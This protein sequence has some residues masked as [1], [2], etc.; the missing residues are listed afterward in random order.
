M[1]R[2]TKFRFAKF[3]FASAIAMA[4]TAA[5]FTPPALAQEDTD[6]RLGTVHFATSCNETAQ[7]R[8]DRGMRYQHSFWYR[9]SEGDFR[10]CAEGRPVLRHRVLGHCAEPPLEPAQRADTGEPAG[11][12][13]G[14]AERQGAWSEDRARAR[15]Y[16]LAP[17]ALHR[18]RQGAARPACTG[19]SQGSR[20]LGPALS[21]RRRGAAQLR[22]HA[23]RRGLAQRQDL[24]QPAQGR[25]DPGA[26]L[27][28]S[29]A[30][31]RRCALPDPSLRHACAGGA[32]ARRR[33]AL[34]ADR[35]VGA[36]RAAHAV[37]HLHARGLLEGLDFLEHGVGQGRAGE[38]G[39]VRP[40]ARPGL[41]GLRLSAARAGQERPCG[42][43]TRC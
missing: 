2:L 19:L 9:A 29:A 20:G 17:G 38:Q 4:A 7:R 27:Q 3:R 1:F 36:A 15:V 33:Q 37:A 28:A 40:A 23:Q 11:G 42:D 14:P 39:G 43:R 30:S 13:R 5:S 16:R 6:Q 18:L 32:R 35:A 8:F 25:C 21:G 26:D 10:G 22:D 24:C 41:S 12:A 31:S 34:F